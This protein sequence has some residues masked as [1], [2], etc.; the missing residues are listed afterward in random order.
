MF[1]VYSPPRSPKF[2]LY[3]FVAASWHSF[4]LL[5]ERCPALHIGTMGGRD[6]TWVRGW[7]CH[8]GLCAL[9]PPCC[10]AAESMEQFPQHCPEQT[11]WL[12]QAQSP[13][14]YIANRLGVYQALICMLKQR[15]KPLQQSRKLWLDLFTTCKGHEQSKVR[16]VGRLC[17]LSIIR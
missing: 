16:P 1:P 14:P 11:A 9:S 8:A 17:S 3:V 13:N 12:A 4:Y 10:A 6:G 7:A 2:L 15:P 5:P